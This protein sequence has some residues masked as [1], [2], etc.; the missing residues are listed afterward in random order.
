MHLVYLSLMTQQTAAIREALQLLTPFHV[1]LIRTV[2]LVHVLAARKSVR[3]RDHVGTVNS[4]PLA[5][6]IESLAATLCV[7]AHH[8][9]IVVPWWF[10]GAFPGMISPG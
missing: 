2:V 6:A 9:A 4:P 5:L 3:M 10:L 7:L 8:L 1:A